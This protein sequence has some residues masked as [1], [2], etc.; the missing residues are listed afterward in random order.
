MQ[1]KIKNTAITAEAIVTKNHT[2]EKLHAINSTKNYTSR[3]KNKAK[4]NV[5]KEST[6]MQRRKKIAC[7]V[8]KR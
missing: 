7:S 4:Q 3:T 8:K 6:K 1:N 2:L 5:K